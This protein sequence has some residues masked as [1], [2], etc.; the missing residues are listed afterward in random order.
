M[1]PVAKPALPDLRRLLKD[2][3]MRDRLTA[4]EALCRIEQ[5]ADALPILL[6]GLRHRE[7][8]TR[9]LAI[10]ALQRLGPLAKGALPALR[11][12]T[13]DVEIAVR[14]AARGCIETIQ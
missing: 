4:A 11:E 7:E 1:G 2:G 6:D 3:D 5:N 10:E 13:Q 12:A 14:V 9:L 8:K